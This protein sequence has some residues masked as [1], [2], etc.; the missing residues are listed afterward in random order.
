MKIYCLAMHEEPDTDALI[1]SGVLRAF[2]FFSALGTWS[3]GDGLCRACQGHSQN[4]IEPLLVQ[5]EPSSD[6][7]GDFSWDGPWGYVFL[8]TEPVVAFLRRHGFECGFLGVEY[9][10]P[11]KASKRYKCVPYPY[12]GPKQYWGKCETFVDLDQ[13]AS[14]VK[15]KIDCPECGRQKHTFRNEGIA[16]PRSNWSGEKMFRI[17]T[18]GKSLATFVTD[19]G[20]RLI[21][22]AG[23]SNIAFRPAG[24]IV[25]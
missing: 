14:G 12:R 20:R 17:R 9:V 21:E 24:E 1:E 2:A 10:E 4:R 22:E 19:E 13:Q 11:E 8:V 25:D 3:K 5:W 23:F 7:I 16:I 15:L 18:N 6:V